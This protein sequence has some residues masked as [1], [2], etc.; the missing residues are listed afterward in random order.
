MNFGLD[1]WV[2]SLS[3]RGYQI[4]KEKLDLEALLRTR[5]LPSYRDDFVEVVALIFDELPSRG[6]CARIARRWREKRLLRPFLIFTDN[7]SSRAAEE[8]NDENV[9]AILSEDAARLFAEEFERMWA[10]SMG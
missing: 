9:F 8:S 7:I 5:V 6:Y 10:L 3:E 1:F 4:R 2:Q